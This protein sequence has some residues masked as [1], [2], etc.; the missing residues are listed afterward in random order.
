ENPEHY[1]SA[2]RFLQLAIEATIDIGSHIVSDLG[3]GQVNWYSDI[4]AILAEKNYISIDLREKWVRMIGFRNIL[5]HDYLQV[6]LRIVYDVLQ[7]RLTDLDELK[8]SFT[9]FL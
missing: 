8:E 7:N 1:G 5:V 3:L 6:D 9:N 4:A 2:E